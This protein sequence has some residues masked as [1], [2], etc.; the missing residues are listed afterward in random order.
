MPK[1]IDEL[2]EE[3]RARLDRVTPEQAQ[4]ELERGA[5]LVDHRTL[6]QRREHGDVPGARVIGRTVLEWRLDPQSLYREPEVIDHDVRIIL[7]CQEGYSSSLAAATLR[8]LGL[9]RATD[10]IGGFE[11]WREAGLPIGPCRDS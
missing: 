5:L 10:V 6:E 3:A 11:A 7:L 2:L 8:E 1:S 4:R 9:E